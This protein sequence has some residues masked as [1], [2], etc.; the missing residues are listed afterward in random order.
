MCLQAFSSWQRIRDSGP[1]CA[2]LCRRI[3]SLCSRKQAAFAA[4]V[5]LSGVI[6]LHSIALNLLVHAGLCLTCHIAGILI[7]KGIT[8]AWPALSDVL[9]QITYN[10]NLFSNQVNIE[11]AMQWWKHDSAFAPFGL[12][13]F[14]VAFSLAVVVYHGRRLSLAL[15]AAISAMVTAC[16]QKQMDSCQSDSMALPSSAPIFGQ[17]STSQG[18][19]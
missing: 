11:N 9:T 8:V 14:Q 19:A 2:F 13:L 16:V 1:V 17:A 15:Q 7:M 10:I 3:S 4:A 12:G 18:A 5:G 6:A